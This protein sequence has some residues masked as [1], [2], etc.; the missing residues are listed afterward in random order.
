MSGRQPGSRWRL[1]GR[2]LSGWRNSL[3]PLVAA[4]VLAP[5]AARVEPYWMADDD[6]TA[7]FSGATISGRY[8]DGRTFVESYTADGKL[9]YEEGERRWQGHWS[10]VSGLFC[11]IYRQSG[12]GGCFRVHRIGPNCF[13]F[14]FQT[15][16]EEEARRAPPERPA[17]TAQGWR[18][19]AIATCDRPAV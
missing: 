15:R 7:A 2:R 8:A 3:A 14:Y 5:A 6:L 4:L 12:T 13:E 16:T 9:R 11:T 17:W 18:T 19:D 1:S 10:V